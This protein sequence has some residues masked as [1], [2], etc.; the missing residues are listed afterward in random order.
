[1]A[2]GEQ[3][4]SGEAVETAGS[5]FGLDL[6]AA[7]TSGRERTRYLLHALVY[8]VGLSL[9]VWPG[10]VPFNTVE[11]YVLGMPFVLF[12]TAFS[13]LVVFANTVLLYRFEYGSF[14]N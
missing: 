11:P 7:R 5:G 14:L 10:V 2:Q 1:M 6:F 8:V 9:V 12:W 13:L 3:R 4:Q